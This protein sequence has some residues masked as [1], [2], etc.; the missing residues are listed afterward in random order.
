[1]P[2]NSTQSEASQPWQPSHDLKSEAGRKAHAQLCKAMQ[3]M[4]E[5]TCTPAGQKRV[6]EYMIHNLCGTYD[7]EFRPGGEEGERAS[8]FA[9]GKRFVGLQMVQMLKTSTAA[10]IGGW[11]AANSSEHGI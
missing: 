11:S 2:N 5:G 7:M 8:I 6:L 1:M 3:Q 9:A 4:A 10:L